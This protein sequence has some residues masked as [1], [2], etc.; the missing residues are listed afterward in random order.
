MKSDYQE[1]KEARIARYHEL[2]DKK[3]AL[4]DQLFDESHKMVEHIPFGQPILVGHHSEKAHRNLLERSRNKMFEGVEEGQKSTYYADKADAAAKNHAISSDDPEAIDKLREKLEKAEKAQDLMKAANKIITKSKKTDEQK[5]E[6]LKGLGFSDEKIAALLHPPSHLW[7][8]TPGFPSYELT[9]NN[10]NVRRMKERLAH[11]EKVSHDITTEETFGDVR[12]VD[13]VEDN[14][15]QVFFPDIPAQEVRTFLSR[16][17]FHWS[18]TVGAWMRQRSAFAL[19]QAKVA[20][21]M[22]SAPQETL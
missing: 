16:N 1:R 20:A 9:N 18:K 22:G 10:A 5:R 14:R 17:G 19:Q 13:N 4:R 6:D 11:L 3:L 12:I 2:A 21:N 15:V 8:R 7:G